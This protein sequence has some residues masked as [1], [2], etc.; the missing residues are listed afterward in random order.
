MTPEERASQTLTFCTGNECD[1][2]DGVRLIAAAIRA[3]V[4][5]ERAE[6]L[7]VAREHLEARELKV[8]REHTGSPQSFIEDGAY[9]QAFLWVKFLEERAK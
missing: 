5:E 1:Q 6:L 3:A 8:R 7:K 2:A 4:A 9:G